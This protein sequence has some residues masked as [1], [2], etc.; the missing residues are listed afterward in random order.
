MKHL[1]ITIFILCCVTISYSQTKEEKKEILKESIINQTAEGNFKIDI[2]TA[3]PRSSNAVYLNS[4]Y[5]ITVRN[6]SIY[7]HLPYYGRAFSVPYAGG[8]GLIFN[9]S[10]DKYEV[11]TGKKGNIT[12]KIETKNEEDRYKYTLTIHPNGTT[13]VSVN[14]INRASISYMGKMDI[15]D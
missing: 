9:A 4:P 5:S 6:D 11:K 8:K 7:S 15:S 13:N 14:M 2:S 1:F 3:L 10:I 12:V